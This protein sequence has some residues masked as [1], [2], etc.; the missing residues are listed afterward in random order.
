MNRSLP[1]WAT[2][3]VFF[4]LAAPA[5]AQN[6]GTIDFPTSGR[7]EAQPA[8]IRGVL[9]LHSFE[10]DA[11]AAAFREAQRLDPGFV[12]AYWG[13]AMTYTHPI[14]NQQ[15]VPAAREALSRL[16]PDAEAR[17]AKAT[18]ARER[19][20]QEAVE[21][22]YGEGSKERRDTLYSTAMER[23][24]AQ[25][26]DD[27]EAQSFFALS[28][29]GLSQGVRNV[30]TYM[31]AAAIAEAVYRRNPMHPGAAHYIIHAFDDPVHAPLGLYAARAYSKIA[32]DAS[33]AQHMT[34]HI[35]LA[36]GLWDDV[37]SQNVIASGPDH[38]QWRP[39]HYTS[40]LGY[41][42]L[43]QGRYEE[44]ARHL[45]LV[46]FNMEASASQRAT[47][48]NMR[49]DYLIATERWAD[50]AISWPIDLGDVTGARAGDAFVRGLAAA[51]RGDRSTAARLLADLQ[52]ASSRSPANEDEAN[53][54]HVIEIFTRELQGFLLWLDG[55][56]DSALAM[57]RQATV[58]E[59]ALPVAFGPPDVVKPSHELLGEML[60]QA[61]RPFAA[62]EFRRALELAPRRALSL[63]G[64][65]RAA[66]AEGDSLTAAQARGELAAVWHA[67]DAGISG[68]DEAR[69]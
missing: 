31:R 44:A 36:L 38:G 61:N 25:Y 41:G 5:S 3:A 40:W 18:T 60:L 58:I 65:M 42:L 21:I 11:A 20:W 69:Q 35:F 54:V 7:P 24:A 6:L 32:P 17:L 45:A 59:D 23:L 39:G 19:G 49:G 27:L 48:A 29:L 33:H 1:A 63:R 30:P 15:D 12:M 4:V 62:A 22:L 34:T 10:Y 67:A 8:F 9:Y 50:A 47:L 14:W 68:L 16:G 2:A 46:R 66:T 28:L 57:V 43:Q 37:V 51:H 64:L 53:E 26:P 56:T 55:Q 52:S 13:E